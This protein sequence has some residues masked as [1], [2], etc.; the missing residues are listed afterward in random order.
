MFCQ[1]R[2]EHFLV[3]MYCRNEFAKSNLYEMDFKECMGIALGI[4]GVSFNFFAHFIIM[5]QFCPRFL[6]RWFESREDRRFEVQELFPTY[7][8]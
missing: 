8:F 1:N 2:A 7:Y 3:H 4:D 5:K 6:C